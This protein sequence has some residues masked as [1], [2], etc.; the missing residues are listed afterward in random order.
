MKPSTTLIIGASGCGK[1]FTLLHE[2]IEK[3]PKFDYILTVLNNLDKLN[4][5]RLEV[6][7]N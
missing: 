2:I 4:L 1:T 7:R 3:E 5:F 6:S